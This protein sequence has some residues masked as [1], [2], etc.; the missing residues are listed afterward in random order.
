MKEGKSAEATVQKAINEA[1]DEEMA[2]LVPLDK[3]IIID[4][5]KKTG[6]LVII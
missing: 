5:V 3:Q 2:R 1:V 6:R 4:S